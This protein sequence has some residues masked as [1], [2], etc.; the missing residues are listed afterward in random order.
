MYKIRE[1]FQGNENEPIVK[2]DLPRIKYSQELENALKDLESSNSY[3]AFELLWLGEERAIYFNGL[4]IE[5]VSTSNTPGSFDVSINGKVDTMRILKFIRYYIKSTFKP[6]E[7]TDFL[8]SYILLSKGQSI[9][10][11]P[12]KVEEFSYDPKNVKKTF[13]SLTTKTYPHGNEE[14]VLKFLPELTVDT[15]GNYYKIIG[16]DKPQTMFTSHLDTADRNQKTTN[17]YSVER[18]GS[19]FIVTDGNSILG[20]DDK[21][22]VTILLYMMAHNVPGL[23]YF[24]VGEERGGIGSNQLSYVYE[25]VEYL[26]DIKRCVS[27]DRRDTC[28]VITKQLGKVCCSNQ[29][30][31]ALCKGYN[32]NGIKLAP[33]PTG[34]YTDS[35]SFLLNI[36]ECTNISVGYYNE[37][38]SGE[39]Q[40]ITFLENL[41]KAS[42]KINWNSLPTARSVGIS[43]EIMRKYGK[44]IATI[45]DA[46]FANQVRIASDEYGGTAIQCDMYSGDI[47]DA[48]DTLNK[49]SS[50]LLKYNIKQD[51]FFEGEYLKISIK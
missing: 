28:S 8:R 12:I 33:D 25:Y 19:E 38:T 48:Y 23:Y 51:V 7:V 50:M 4:G 11:N 37:H 26:K 6:D 32:E 21:A 24:F 9:T 31:E 29:F 49:L 43:K 42:V 47:E 3:V 22:G 16:S 13:L 46:E 2:K 10:G 14:Q 35:A 30:A 34:I 1:H 18:D 40:N 39:K 15:V 41:C 36:P 27:F 20:S 44:L 5:L 17:L 45:K